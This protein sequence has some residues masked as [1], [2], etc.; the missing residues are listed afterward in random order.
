LFEISHVETTASF[1]RDVN[2]I[3]MCELLRIRLVEFVDQHLDGSIRDL[4]ARDLISAILARP[5]DVSGCVTMIARAAAAAAT[6]F[7]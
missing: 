2:R 6:S 5:L 3:V 1:H 4:F 7:A